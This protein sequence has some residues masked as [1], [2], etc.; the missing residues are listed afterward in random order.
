MFCHRGIGAN[1]DV[2]G[3]VLACFWVLLEL[4]WGPLGVIMGA[5]G[6]PVPTAP[7]GVEAQGFYS[8][9]STFFHIKRDKV[10]VVRMLVGR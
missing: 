2:V 10:V 4:S 1:V 6:P 5:L 3:A 7:R 8:Y 9:P